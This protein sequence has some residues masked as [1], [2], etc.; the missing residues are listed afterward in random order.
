MLAF[1]GPARVLAQTLGLG[2]ASV[3]PVVI[4]ELWFPALVVGSTSDP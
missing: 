3:G 1:P 4:Q 2:V